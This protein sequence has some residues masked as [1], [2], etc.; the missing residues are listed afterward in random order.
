MPPDVM[1]IT[2]T[3]VTLPSRS[4]VADRGHFPT[5]IAI[6]WTAAVRPGGFLHLHDVAGIRLYR[7]RRRRVASPTVSLVERPL[8]PAL[9]LLDSW[10]QASGP[11]DRNDAIDPKLP[12]RFRLRCRLRRRS[13]VGWTTIPLRRGH[14][15]L[16]LVGHSL[17]LV[18]M[19]DYLE[20]SHAEEH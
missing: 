12:S 2:V 13:I 6:G 11:I 1:A 9:C 19:Q 5:I 20:S 17:P 8:F 10:E 3:A 18:F 14:G 7:P 15:G 4:S 16:R